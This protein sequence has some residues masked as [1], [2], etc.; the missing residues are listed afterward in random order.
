MSGTERRAREVDLEAISKRLA[1]TLNVAVY[2][3][4]FLHVVKLAKVNRSWESQRA[5]I[6]ASTDTSLA[7]IH[8]HSSPSF[9]LHNVRL[10]NP[11]TPHTAIERA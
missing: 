3:R 2:L 7:G 11:G 6:S 5:T 1:Q 4:T 8:S 9:Y 10:A